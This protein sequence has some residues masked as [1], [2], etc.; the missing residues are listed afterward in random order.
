MSDFIE[1]KEIYFPCDF[2]KFFRPCGMCKWFCTIHPETPIILQSNS[3]TL[4][5]DEPY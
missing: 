2:W 1:L 3:E 5:E 4:M